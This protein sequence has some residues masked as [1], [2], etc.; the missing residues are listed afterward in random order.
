M[1]SEHVHKF[2]IA[3]FDCSSSTDHIRVSGRI[4]A[5]LYLIEINLAVLVFI[6]SVKS[7]SYDIRTVGVHISKDCNDE[8][9]DANGSVS[10]VIKDGKDLIGFWSSTSNPV[11]IKGSAELS[12]VESSTSVRVHNFK[13]ALQADQTFS[14]TL[15]KFLTKA[16]NYQL[17]LFD[18]RK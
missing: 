1:G 15:N 6:Q 5:G 8:F 7:L 3:I 13:L 4:E 17:V 2:L 12:K 10:V 18:V 16:T 14:S 9:I 11:I